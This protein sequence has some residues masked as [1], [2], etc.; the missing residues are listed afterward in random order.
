MSCKAGNLNSSTEAHVKVEGRNNSPSCPLTSIY[1]PWHVCMFIH[2]AHTHIITTTKCWGRGEGRR[3]WPEAGAQSCVPSMDQATF[4]FSG[5]P[6]RCSS[7]SQ[8]E[9]QPL[10]PPVPSRVDSAS[11]LYLLTMFLSLALKLLNEEEPVDHSSIGRPY[12][13]FLQ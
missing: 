9:A 8:L 4:Y 10:S 3:G 12:S 6:A 11:S 2:A 1:V 13:V 5:L 7:G